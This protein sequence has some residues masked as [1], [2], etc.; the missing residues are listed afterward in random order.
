[1]PLPPFRVPSIHYKNTTD[2]GYSNKKSRTKT[3]I[4]SRKKSKKYKISKKN[5]K[6]KKNNIHELAKNIKIK[7]YTS[8]I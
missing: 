8:Y 1:M 2:G 7:T 6:S 3:K 4:Y 5:K